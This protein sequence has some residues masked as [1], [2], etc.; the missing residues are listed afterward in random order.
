MSVFFKFSTAS[1][2]IVTS[3]GLSL[4]GRAL[5]NGFKSVRSLFSIDPSS[6]EAQIPLTDIIRTAV[7]VLINGS[8][9]YDAVS[10]LHD[11]DEFYARA[12]DIEERI[13]SEATLR[14][15][16]DKYA[17]TESAH[18]NIM[19]LNIALLKNNNVTISPIVDDLVNIDCDVSPFDNS[20]TKKEGVGRTYKGCDGYA[21]MM[22]YIGKEGLALNNE[23]RPGTQHS[24]KHTPEFLVETI[25][26]AKRLTSNP[27]LV[28]LDSGNDAGDNIHVCQGMN[29]HYLIKRNLRDEEAASWV[30][31]AMHEGTEIKYPREGKTVWFGT[32]FRDTSYTVT[33]EYCTKGGKVKSHTVRKKLTDIKVV[34]EVTMRTT[35][36]NGQILLIPEIEA[37]TYWTDLN[38][39]E[40]DIIQLYHEHG[41]MEQYHSEFKTD[42]DLERLP[43]GK[44]AT[45]QLILDIATLA[46]NI[47]RLISQHLMNE[48]IPLKSGVIRRRVKTIIQYMIRIPAHITSHAGSLFIGLGK[49]NSFSKAF[50]NIYQTLCAE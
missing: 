28:R 7:G 15:R 24:Q 42:M 31:I 12:L 49:S 50:Q 29:A 34:Y 22:A 26:M 46:F 48:C 25:A 9:E 32:C 36:K 37:D 10:Q 8:P 38:G 16:L 23:F 5:S 20:K 30:D 40:E 1:E 13:P 17:P 6:P 19:E 14:Q 11:D 18:R 4:V 39:K 27:L 2:R 47:T 44:F 41:E 21:P 33:E 43:S 35:D 45:N 3:S